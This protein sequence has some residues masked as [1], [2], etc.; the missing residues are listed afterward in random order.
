MYWSA[1]NLGL[2]AKPVE[3]NLWDSLGRW[4]VEG[5]SLGALGYPDGCGG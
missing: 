5:R 3:L 2:G 4:V 1:A